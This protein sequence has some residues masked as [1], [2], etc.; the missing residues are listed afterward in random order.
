MV[1]CF[2]KCIGWLIF[3][4]PVA[5]ILVFCYMP[6]MVV[7]LIACLAGCGDKLLAYGFGDNWLVKYMNWY[8]D[9]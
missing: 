4:F 7:G 8:A 3:V 1:K 5:V 2:F 6:F 9:L